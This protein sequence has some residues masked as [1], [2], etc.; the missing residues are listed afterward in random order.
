MEPEHES[1]A[2]NESEE[3]IESVSYIILTDT[4]A[5]M[6]NSFY[7][8][9]NVYVGIQE[10]DNYSD[11]SFI[12]LSVKRHLSSPSN[13]HWEYGLSKDVDVALWME[14]RDFNNDSSLREVFDFVVVNQ[15]LH[16]E[17]DDFKRKENLCNYSILSVNELLQHWNT[18]ERKPS[19]PVLTMYGLKL[20]YTEMDELC[21]W[22]MNQ[23]DKKV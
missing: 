1:K 6:H 14:S 23:K 19:H 22:V 18:Y 15:S 12:D 11:M 9:L 3:A 5:S 16:S 10:E 17:F 7:H 4:F 20:H 2:L 13:I 21:E 8:F